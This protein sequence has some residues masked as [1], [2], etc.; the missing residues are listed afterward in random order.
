MNTIRLGIVEDNIPYMHT[1]K[2]SLGQSPDIDIVF[3]AT[4]GVECMQ[5]LETF[6]PEALPHVILMD[7]MMPVMDG[8]K[9][10]AA[11]KEF[12]PAIEILM[13][14]SSNEDVYIFEAIRHGAN[15]YVLKTDTIENIT[16]AIKEIHLG[17][18][19]MSPS[20]A[21]KAILWFK[22]ALQNKPAKPVKIPEK[23]IPILSLKEE[24][25]LHLLA[26]GYSYQKIA[27]T[28]ILS[29]GTIKTHVNNIYTKLHINNRVEAVNKLSE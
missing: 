5:S 16:K 6:S 22:D 7:I 12:A 20:I 13:C 9:T 17:G 8:I 28:L 27:D 10:A 1:L 29:L 23:Q 21:Q 19:P 18:I 3:T 14:T 26:K 4:D 2:L 15:G 24:E 25:V 11:V